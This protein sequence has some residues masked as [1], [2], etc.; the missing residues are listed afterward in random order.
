MEFDPEN[1]MRTTGECNFG[2]GWYD[3]DVVQAEDYDRLLALYRESERGRNEDFEVL[4][5]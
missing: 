2:E 3:Y 4:E 5:E 1:V